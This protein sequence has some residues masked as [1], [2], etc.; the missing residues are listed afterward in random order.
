MSLYHSD[1]TP[2]SQSFSGVLTVE[3][4]RGE[5]LKVL[6]ERVRTENHI[7]HEVPITYAGRLDPMAEGVVML[8]V[9]EK[10]FEKES[11]LAQDKTYRFTILFGITTDSLDVLGLAGIPYQALPIDGEAIARYITSITSLA[12]PLY[13]SRPVDGKPLFA[14]ARAGTMPSNI[15][16]KDVHIYSC[17]C[18]GMETVPLSILVPGIIED[19]KKVSG[20]FRQEEIIAMWQTYLNDPTPVTLAT[21]EAVVSS[22]AYIRSLAEAA[23][24]YC[25][26]PALAYRIVRTQIGR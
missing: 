12:Y 2:K 16:T 21:F 1:N 7:T 11:Y 4:A 18:Q 13:S 8:L 9:G 10:R 20:D 25:A 6:L 19:I 17:Q 26:V 23:G 22:G 24:K 14:Y 15:P 5:T 3:K